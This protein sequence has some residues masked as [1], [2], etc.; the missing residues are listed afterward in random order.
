MKVKATADLGRDPVSSLVFRLAIPSM[1]AQLVNVL[2]S[3]VD[4]MYIGH[5]PQVG[6]LALAGAGICGPIVTLLSS[7]GT[8]VGLGGSILMGIRMGEKNHQKAKQLLA[9]S[10]LLLCV[11][12]LLLTIGFLLCKE[13]LL[14]LFGA[15]ASTFPYANTYMTIY[16]AGSFFALMASGLNY[17]INCQGFPMIGM[18]TVLIGAISNIL[19]DPVFIFVLHMG[20]GGAALAT[21]I[22]QIASFLFALWFLMGPRI[23]VRISF[24]QYDLRIMGKILYLGLSPFL[25]L[26][27]DSA[28][29]IVMN[30][31]LQ[32]YGGSSGDMLITCATIA[33]SYLLLITSPMIGIS[34]G[35]QA[36]LSYNY[37]ARETLRV[38]QAEKWI[39]A[40][41]LSFTTFMFLLS[42]FIPRY[43]V[44]LFTTQPDYVELSI[45][46]IQVYTMM[47]IPLSFQF[48]FVDGLTALER[49]KTALCL[50]IAR[51][52]TYVLCTFLL[53]AF[54]TAKAAFY[55]EPIADILNSSVT[56]LVFFLVINRHLAKREQASHSM[57]SP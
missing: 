34:G 31:V 6:D 5:I 17:F 24:G 19:L 35:T 27:T 49:A 26:A 1:V 37:G 36:I 23:H 56:T 55:A 29:L 11:F 57:A 22:S 52:S 10:F 18:A 3:I 53:P 28:L 39:L 4:R 32:K 30:T 33:Q 21:V 47:I 41:M 51:K 48:V 46:A 8:L 20:V 44:R 40:L 7:F 42:R 50:S 15:S 43:F 54:F 2:Y 16:T 13:K 14:M 12:S 38:K 9:N 45:W 25:I